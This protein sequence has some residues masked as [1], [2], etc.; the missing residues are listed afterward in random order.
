M[1]LEVLDFIIVIGIVQG[2]LFSLAILFS[3]YFKSS[4]NTYLGISMLIGIL[5]NV[6]Y[7]AV[8]Y[9]WYS[10]FPKFA[11]F[12]DIELVLLFP[13]TLLFYYVKFLYPKFKLQNKYKLLFLPFSISVLVN[14]HVGGHAHFKLYSLEDLSWVPPFYTVEYFFSIV[15]NI[16]ILVVTYVLL[17]KKTN[18]EHPLVN[19]SLK[20]IKLF[21]YF[22]VA[23][24]ITWISLEVVEKAY[25]NDFNFILWLILNLLFYWVGYIG[26]FK[27]RLARNRYEIRKLI[28]KEVKT[29]TIEVSIKDKKTELTQDKDNEYLQDLVSILENEYI[30]RD[31]KLSRNDM[32]NRLGISVGYLSQMINNNSKKSFSDYINYYRVEDVKQMVLNTDFNKYSMLAIGLE[33]GYNSKSAFYSGFK[34]ETGLTPSEFKKSHQIS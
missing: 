25:P 17:F 5:T 27:F 20:W 30:Y 21:F 31:P 19:H 32:A 13:I 18:T 4:T 15:L 26:I 33:A 34:K 22:H 8:K 7:L 2:V 11:I 28:D 24:I 14:L 12:E 29:E 10:E 9:R 3:K 16:I 6:Q 1:N 23:I